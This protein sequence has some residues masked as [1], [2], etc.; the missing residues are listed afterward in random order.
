MY[1][2]LGFYYNPLEDVDVFV[3][4]NKLIMFRLGSCSVAKSS[5]TLC[6][7][8]DS[9]PPGTSV[10][11]I[12]PGKNTGVCCHSLLQGIFPTQRLN[13]GLLHCRQILYQLSH[14]ASPQTRQSGTNLILVFKTLSL[15]ICSYLCLPVSVIRLKLYGSIHRVGLP[16]WH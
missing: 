5:P 14:Q 16:R 13:L 8:M 6:N 4:E 3:L 12:Y 10:Y 7:P 2:I 9:S 15:W 11:G 1:K